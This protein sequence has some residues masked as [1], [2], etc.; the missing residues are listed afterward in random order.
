M[1]N[2]AKKK[3]HSHTYLT[4]KLSLYDVRGGFSSSS[5][6]FD[7]QRHSEMITKVGAIP[8][9]RGDDGEIKIS[10]KKE[11]FGLQCHGPRGTMRTP[12]SA[13]AEHEPAQRAL[14]LKPFNSLLGR[15]S[16]R[17]SEAT[18]W[19]TSREAEET[20]AT[21]STNRPKALE[22]D[23]MSALIDLNPEANAKKVNGKLEAKLLEEKI[24]LRRAKLGLAP[25][26]DLVS[27]NSTYT[28]GCNK[29]V[30]AHIAI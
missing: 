5:E 20:Q 26:E 17:A 30:P 11:G 29:L 24:L 14:S 21:K 16:M 4:Q 6:V 2:N 15:S 13:L 27:Y 19:V 28:S 3:M 18:G 12:K 8:V 23:A 1:A 7:K 22:F 25:D 10:E 9:E